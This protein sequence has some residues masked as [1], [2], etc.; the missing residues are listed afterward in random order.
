MSQNID[1]Q[2]INNF[3]FVRIVIQSFYWSAYVFEVELSLSVRGHPFTIR[4]FQRNASA[5]KTLVIEMHK[6]NL[7]LNGTRS[8]RMPLDPVDRICKITFVYLVLFTAIG[9]C[10][11]LNVLK[12]YCC[13]RYW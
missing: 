1:T 6:I 3:S 12:L 2:K 11:C 4:G 9:K 13:N 5:I 10:D 7:I 8:F